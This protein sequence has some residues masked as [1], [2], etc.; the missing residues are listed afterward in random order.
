[1]S[2]N[3]KKKDQS[4]RSKAGRQ[5]AVCEIQKSIPIYADYVESW[6]VKM[7]NTEI[8]RNENLTDLGDKIRS[9]SRLTTLHRVLQRLRQDVKEIIIER[10]S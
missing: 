8:K 6:L 1:M 4:L 2:K 9:G 5:G 10:Q 7:I 3:Q